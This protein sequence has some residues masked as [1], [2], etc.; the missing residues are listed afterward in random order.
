MRKILRCLIIIICFI[1]CVNI[2]VKANT[3]LE[4]A[5]D[6]IESN[7]KMEE[8]YQYVNELQIGDEVLGKINAKEYISTYLKTGED[9]ISMEKIWDSIVSFL[10]KEVKLILKLVMSIL[11]IAL[12]SAILKSLQDAFSL[13]EGVSSIAFY[14][15]FALLIML[16]SKSFLVSLN[17]ARDVLTSLVDFMNVLLP[18]LVLLIS[19]AGGIASAMT[20]DP[21][22]LGAVA[23]T[24]RI[25]MN[26]IFPLILIYFAL[27]FA[28]NLSSEFSIGRM[29]KFVKQI[30]MIS[31]GFVLTVFVAI[32]T[33][34]G[35]T[36]NTLDAVALKTVKFAVDNFIPIVGKAFSDAI[37]T[38]AGYSLAMKSVV[39]TLGVIILVAMV[40]YPIIKMAVMIISFK[41]T[42]AV[43][44]PV[45]DSRISSSVDMVGDALVMILSC[46][47]SV[48]I[49]FFI[50][51]TMIASSGKFIVGG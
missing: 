50:M 42:A 14:A 22:V 15:C 31:Q 27:Q 2:N 10:F 39:S 9:P 34:R 4:E 37:S 30:V 38:V 8:F 28:N 29:C 13:D 18:V 12:L 1:M 32:L 5:K 47:I 19:T 23:I 36:A 46:I 45:V 41:L 40:L 20:I 16:L 24:P 43:I 44:E 25:Y 3:E 48:S 6:K 51:A 33:I 11:V 26:F 7:T 35:I 49:M 17:L 21:I